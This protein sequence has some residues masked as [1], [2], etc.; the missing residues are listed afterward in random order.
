MEVALMRLKIARNFALNLLRHRV[1][2][3]KIL[4]ETSNTFIKKRK[5]FMC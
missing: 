4:I 3:T 2:S 1:T 5:A